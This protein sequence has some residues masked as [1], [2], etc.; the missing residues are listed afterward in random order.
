MTT[1]RYSLAPTNLGELPVESQA[2]TLDGI[3]NQM[4]SAHDH[5]LLS[6]KI[7]ET[8]A[9]EADIRLVRETGISFG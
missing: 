5:P 9:R 2:G 8:R 1:T 6:K 3:R 7:K 4:G